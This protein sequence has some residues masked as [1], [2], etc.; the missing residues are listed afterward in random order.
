MDNRA[1]SSGAS[2]SPPAAPASPSVG[3]PTPGDPLTATPATKG[4]AFWFHQI[5]EEL[6]AVLTAAGITP[7][8]ASTAQLLEAIQRLID[9]QSLYAPHEAVTPNMTVVLNA[10]A[11][12]NG[13]TLTENAQQTT[14]TITAPVSNPRIDRIVIDS[15]TGV[16]SVIAGAEAA[17]PTPP[18]LTSG[19]LPIARVL[20]Q[21]SS[22]TITNSMLT[23]ERALIMGMPGYATL[24]ANI[25]TGVQT[26]QAKLTA[27][28]LAVSATLVDAGLVGMGGDGGGG[29]FINGGSSGY[30]T[31]GTNAAGYAVAAPVGFG[32]GRSPICRLDITDSVSTRLANFNSTGAN[33]VGIALSHSSVDFAFFGSDKWVGGGLLGDFGLSATGSIYLR[34]TTFNLPI[35]Q[36]LYV[37]G[38]SLSTAD[39]VVYAKSCAKVWVS[40][41]GTAA[42]PITPIANLNC[43]SITKN[44]TGD[45]TLNF[46][47][48]LTDANYAPSITV[49]GS[50]AGVQYGGL[51][52]S[53]AAGSAP[54]T[55]STTALRIN[56]G[57]TYGGSNADMKSVN[58]QIFGN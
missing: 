36:S 34:S 7:S 37:G 40:F 19:K 28:N 27:T 2:A 35:A 30:V 23:D 3:Y 42:G 10:G 12:F 49:N 32:V 29:L 44:G 8:T 52:H 39:G 33:G 48:A 53:S 56:T 22:T 47:S 31:L 18:A 15:T 4:G 14:D 38:S 24:G 17:S 41:D 25:F 51:I 1:W 43:G 21:T 11:L 16:V 26:V 55:K 46:S 54:T 13:T 5:G 9:A 57:T 58:V 6:R 50:A 20:L 45:Y